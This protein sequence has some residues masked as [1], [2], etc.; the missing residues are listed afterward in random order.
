[1]AGTVS[2]TSVVGGGGE[3]KQ[4]ASLEGA[5][6]KR[7]RAPKRAWYDHTWATTPDPIRTPQ[8]SAHGPE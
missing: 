2:D 6:T 8:I 3:R 5:R 7:E 1:M 4:R